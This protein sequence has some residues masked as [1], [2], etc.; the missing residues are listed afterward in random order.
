[1]IFVINP[2]NNWKN[3]QDMKKEEHDTE[4]KPPTSAVVRSNK[5]SKGL[6]EKR[7]KHLEI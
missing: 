4:A 2:A 7:N 1:L 6:K 5:T 3:E